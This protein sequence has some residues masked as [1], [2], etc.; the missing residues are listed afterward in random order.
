[1]EPWNI[2]NPSQC[3]TLYVLCRPD[4]GQCVDRGAGGGVERAGLRHLCHPRHPLPPDPA[5][6]PRRPTGRDV[7]APRISRLHPQTGTGCALSTQLSKEK[8]GNLGRR[9][10][11]AFNHVPLH[12]FGQQLVAILW[13]TRGRGTTRLIAAEEKLGGFAVRTWCPI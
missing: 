3:V 2:T 12:A 4:R 7:E 5:H 9:F 10:S 6:A 8:L 11:E 1:M 13:L